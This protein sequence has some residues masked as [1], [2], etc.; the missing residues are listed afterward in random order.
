[1]KRCDMFTEQVSAYID[2]ELDYQEEIELFVHLEACSLCRQMLDAC[3]LTSRALSD[4]EVEPPPTLV[5][6]VMAQI[7]R[8]PQVLQFPARRRS[9]F[10]AVAAVFALVVFAG[11]SGIWSGLI[12]G[13]DFLPADRL[14]AAPAPEAPAA[15]V[16]PE[17]WV[18]G[19][20]DVQMADE[21]MPEAE[22][23]EEF[24]APEDGRLVGENFAPIEI[25]GRPDGMDTTL[26]DKYL[27]WTDWS[28]NA[29]A[30][31]LERNG[32]SYELSEGAFVVRDIWNPGSYLYGSFRDG[33][34][35]PGEISLIGYHLRLDTEDRRV[36]IRA[37]EREK[38]YF[39]AVP[40]RA[41]GGILAQ[42]RDML[43]DFVL[44]G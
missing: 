32:F 33:A 20:P 3:R 11:L 39:Y 1:M 4:W 22:E 14:L 40:R 26:L 34:E 23:M 17:E 9:R 36:E 7:D 27:T 12:P 25:L 13:A 21:A 6:N 2:G 35:V 42:W 8:E 37:E 31:D 24:P 30:R 28:W 5:D 41:E 44:F 29:L 18:Y 15:A 38:L 16:A 10:L 19:E 43:R